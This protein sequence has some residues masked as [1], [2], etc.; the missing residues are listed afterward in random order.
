[1]FLATAEEQIVTHAAYVTYPAF[2]SLEEWKLYKGNCPSLAFQSSC[3][4]SDATNF[5]HRSDSVLHPF[6]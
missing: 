6:L 1:M 3:G 5:Y 2:I 4:K